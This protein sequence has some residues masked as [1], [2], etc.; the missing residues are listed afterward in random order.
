MQKAERGWW[1][2]SFAQAKAGS[3]YWYRVDD[4][5][6]VP[7][8]R[9][10]FQ[11][12]GVHG[13]SEIID[14]FAFAWTD[15][16]WQPSPLASALIYEIHVGTFTPQGTFVAAIEKLDYLV[17]LGVT[18]VEVMPVNEFSGPWGWGYDGVDLYAPHHQYGRPDDFKQFIN[19]CHEKGLAVLLDAV[20]NHFGPAGNYLGLF[21]PYLTDRYKTPWGDAVNLDGKGSDEVRRFF[22]DN[23]LMWLRDYHIR[24]AEARRGS[25]FH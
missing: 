20:Y 4:S 13:P 25:R 19:A 21:G 1:K 10:N 17:E 15:K 11:P 14:H 16:K 8:P 2:G 3:R 18:H 24:R 6:P 23:V 22:I 5:K 12:E 7:D 9:S